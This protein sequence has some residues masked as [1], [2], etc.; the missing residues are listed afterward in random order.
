MR[1]CTFEGCNRTLHGRGLCSSHLR[2]M[3]KGQ[4]LLPIGAPENM[5]RKQTGPRSVRLRVAKAARPCAVERCEA[6]V[7]ARGW[8]ATHYGRWMQHGDPLFVK[9][10]NNDDRAR[11]STKYV[12]D[13]ISG[14]WNWMGTID[15]RNYGRFDRGGRP[16]KAHR[17]SYEMHVS[18]IP[19][20]L[21]IDHLC[22]NT[23]C[24]NPGHLEPVTGEENRRRA[25][26]ARRSA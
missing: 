17:V 19:S 11:F 8:C 16:Q 14:C 3:G 13:D 12:I 4:Q 2:Q 1:T 23:R 21:E 6:P 5:T 7:R 15:Q 20:G 18:P 10:I 9:Q 25:L 24:V 22:R 26:E